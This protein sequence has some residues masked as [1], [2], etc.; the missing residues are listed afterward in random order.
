VIEA[1]NRAKERQ[2]SLTHGANLLVLD[3]MFARDAALPRDARPVRRGTVMGVADRRLY[4]RL[5]QPAVDVK[6]YDDAFSGGSPIARVRV[7]DR[8]ID[9]SLGDVVGVRLAQ[10]DPKRRRWLL[11]LV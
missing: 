6:V 5:D 7:G 10:H 4:V 9:C 3:R 1:A 11:E 2:R 8:T